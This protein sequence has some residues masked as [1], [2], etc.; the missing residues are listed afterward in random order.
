M[1]HAC[2][3]CVNTHTRDGRPPFPM[4]LRSQ[5]DT[6]P[7]SSVGGPSSH[8]AFPLPSTNLLQAPTS[9][10]RTSEM[11]T[12]FLVAGLVS[13]WIDLRMVARLLVTLISPA[14]VD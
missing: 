12:R 8:S 1:R 11:L 13:S 4:L 5:S 6:R 3:W 10:C 9:S 14:D 2:E 7:R